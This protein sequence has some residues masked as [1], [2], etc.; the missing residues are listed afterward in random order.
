MV[1]TKT[2]RLKIFSHN[3]PQPAAPKAPDLGRLPEILDAFRQATG[4]SLEYVPHH[5]PSQPTDLTWSPPAN[6]GAGKTPGH[7]RIDPVGS[8]SLKGKARTRRDATERLAS[9]VGGVI[10]ELGRTQSALRQREAELAAGI[11]V[12]PRHE[13]ESHLA[14]RLE[15]TLK[16]GAEGIGCNAA[17]LYLLDDATSHLKL[18]ASWGLLSERFTDPPRRLQGALAD[19]EAMLGHAVVMENIEVARHFNAPEDCPAAVCVPVC[20]PTTILG[21][22]WVFSD[23]AQDF[24]TQQTNVVELAAGR[25]AADLERHS[26]LEA[27]VQAEGWKRQLAEAE[28]LQRNQLP[29]ISP[30]LDG[31]DVAGWTKQAEAVGGDFFDWFGLSDGL[32][33]V[34][35]GDAMQRGIEAALSAATVKAALRSH[36]QYIRDADILL[37]QTNLT[38]WRGSA[39]DQFASVFCGMIETGT[40]KVQCCQA[41]QQTVLLLHSG[42]WKSL[43]QPSPPLGGGPETQ[44]TAREFTLEPGEALVVFTNGFS[45]ALSADGRRLGEAGLAEAMNRRLDDPA[46]KLV[47]LARRRL[48]AHAALPEHDDRTVLVIKRSAS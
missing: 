18:R 40:G 21:T 41:G 6:P 37:S 2:T 1:P 7:L 10:G 43:T 29:T 44:Y 31:W 13:G 39:G 38:L 5:T 47:D 28:R 45:D 16:S 25:I 8:E 46:Q 11:P 9:A 22:L 30:L 3:E 14:S 4:W 24:S 26:L 32:I 36:G 15:A 19:L 17:A 33:G 27:G 48:N 23:T 20:S 35:V 12:A 34:T 42:G